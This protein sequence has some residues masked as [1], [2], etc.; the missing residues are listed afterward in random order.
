MKIIGFLLGASTAIIFSSLAAQATEPM[1]AAQLDTVRAGTDPIPGVD[2]KLGHNPGGI[3]VAIHPGTG[4]QVKIG[5]SLSVSV[6]PNGMAINN[7]GCCLP[8]PHPPHS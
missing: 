8:P 1:S 4:V 3:S 6:G 7:N 5:T 2:V